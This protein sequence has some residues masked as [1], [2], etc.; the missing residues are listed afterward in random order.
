M[1]GRQVLDRR[2]RYSMVVGYGG[3]GLVAVT[4]LGGQAVGRSAPPALYLSGFA[5][6]ALAGIYA[7]FLGL[8]CQWC[9]GNLGG[10]GFGWGGWSFD[11][12][13]QCCPYCGR[14]LDEELPAKH[15]AEPAGASDRGGGK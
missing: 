10:L 6:M 7:H 14:G 11:R 13:V 1:T 9:R 5:L 3:A 12:R 4:L 2:V 8:R 15:T